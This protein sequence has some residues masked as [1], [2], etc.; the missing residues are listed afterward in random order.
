MTPTVMGT[1]PRNWVFLGDSLTEG[2]GQNRAT[3][4]TELAKL[5]RASPHRQ[6]AVHALRLRDVEPDSFNPY[7]RTNLA[8]FLEPDPIGAE[9]ALWIWNLASEGRTIETDV[10]W[11]PLL[12]NLSPEHIF[13]YRGSLESIVR[14]AA[15]RDGAW[16]A[17]VPRSWR[18]FVAM[19]PRCYFSETWHRR[20]KQTTIDAMKQR[21]RLRLLAERAGHPL[22]DAST[23]LRH[24]D[25]L[26][27][28]LSGL[29]AQ[30]HMLGLIA[31]EEDCFPGT[32]A[33]YAALNEQLRALARSAAVE[34]VDWSSDVQERRG[35]SPWRFRDGFHPNQTG[36][37]L[38]GG[39]LYD[40][41]AKAA[42]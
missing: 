13:I 9:P 4:V 21:V 38:L 34:F 16:P 17:W 1:R 42:V 27:T 41:V 37:E 25:G 7:I 12:R 35:A 8:G 33:H 10:Q 20:L 30:V 32:P 15:V 3:Y 26:L 14:P 28:S 2:L 36:A 29:G 31:P 18:G 6:S 11:L 40:R 24:Y 39:I 22:L 23:L 19:D 5:L